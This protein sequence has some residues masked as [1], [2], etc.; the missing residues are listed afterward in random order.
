MNVIYKG[1]GEGKTEELLQLAAKDQL[2]L[3]LMNRSECMRIQRRAVDLNLTIPM[4]ITHTDF[5]EGH[6]GGHRIKGLLIDNAEV[7]LQ[8]MT[9]ISV[10]AI[11]VNKEE[12]DV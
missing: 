7:F 10:V 9:H 5:L 12:Q 3:V 2:T 1:R 8:K 6:R 4:L 11:S